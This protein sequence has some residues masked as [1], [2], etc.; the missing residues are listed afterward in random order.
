MFLEGDAGC[1]GYVVNISVDNQTLKLRFTD[2]ADQKDEIENYRENIIST[3]KFIETNE[4][5]DWK[6]YRNEKYKY[7]IKYPTKLDFIKDWQLTEKTSDPDDNIA[8]VS[9]NLYE[10]G[11]EII[12]KDKSYNMPLKDWL[13]KNDIYGNIISLEKINFNGLES[14]K[15]CSKEPVNINTERIYFEKN[16]NLYQISFVGKGSDEREFEKISTYSLFQEILSTF[17]FTD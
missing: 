9:K 14:Y 15:V 12:I 6:T 3:F 8:F 11:I 16:S 10:G 4:T 1:G 5:A 13:V 7:S 2:C 17:K